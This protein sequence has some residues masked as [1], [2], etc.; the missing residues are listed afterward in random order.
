MSLQSS[1][2]KLQ[3]SVDALAVDEGNEN[4]SP[5]QFVEYATDQVTQ[6]AT[7]KDPTLRVT[8]LK[9]LS[10]QIG[11]AKDFIGSPATPGGILSVK[12]FQ[13]PAQVKT[14]EKTQSPSNATAVTL[15]SSNAIPNAEAGAG[16]PIPGGKVPPIVAPGSGFDSPSTATFAKSLDDMGTKIDAL[17]AKVAKGDDKPD[18]KTNADKADDKTDDKADDKTDDKADAD[19]DADKPDA[20]KTE[21]SEGTVWPLDMNSKFGMGETEDPEKPDWGWDHGKG[22][23]EAE[24]EKIAKA[25]AEKIAKTKVEKIAKAKADAK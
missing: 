11:I 2:E 23:T 18:D 24:A 22:T 7:D 6:A 20:E 21:K 5:E 4:M 25:E 8:R 3:K 13:D 14:T 19:K 12:R 17:I 10:E 9:A 15:I 1:L 16:S